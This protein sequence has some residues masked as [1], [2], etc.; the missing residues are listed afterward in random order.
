MSQEPV[1]STTEIGARLEAALAF[2][3]EAGAVTLRYF[4][5]RGGVGAGGFEVSTKR[6]GSEVT[7]ADRE[8]EQRLR[9][10][11]ERAFPGDGV[12]GEEFGERPSV[13]GWRW[14]LDPIDGTASFVHGVPLYGTLVACEFGGQTR[15][16]VIHMPVL[17]ETVYA[18]EGGGAW[19]IGR[20]GASPARARVSGI[21]STA[22]AMMC[23]TSY[24]YYRQAGLEPALTAVFE[25]FGKSRGWSDCYAHVLC[26]TGRIEA[27]V[28]PVLHPWDI[29]P[30]QVIY[31]EA[32][33]R[34]TDWAGR[35]GSYH[36]TGVSTNG[37]VHEELLE[38]LAPF[39]R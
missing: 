11:I 21:S 14:V 6:D 34:T 33:G 16:G 23:T 36:P 31:A 15:A 19:H 4:G 26:A 13:S 1:V 3:R 2:A 8:A 17:G 10:L 27:V 18:G 5:A 28:E 7:T 25:R 35:P 29:A 37:L 24:G 38:L 39:A 22:E 30:M 9:G 20:E 32:G 12:L